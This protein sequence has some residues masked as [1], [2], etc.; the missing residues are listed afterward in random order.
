[1]QMQYN[2][3]SVARTAI[4]CFTLLF[5]METICGNLLAISGFRFMVS[6]AA[7]SFEAQAHEWLV[8]WVR[9]LHAKAAAPSLIT[10]HGNITCS[11]CVTRPWMCVLCCAVSLGAKLHDDFQAQIRAWRGCSTLTHYTSLLP[12]CSFCVARPWVCLLCCAVSLGAK[13]HDGIQ[14]QIRA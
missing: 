1:M 4:T 6:A 3:T 14:A 7:A 10:H 11:S 12:T 5:V 9:S 2:N 13:L 8:V